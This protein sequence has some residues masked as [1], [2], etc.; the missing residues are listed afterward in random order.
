MRGD[1]LATFEAHQ[2][3][4]GG[5][6]VAIPKAPVYIVGDAGG[7]GDPIMGEGIY[8]ALESGRI[9]GETIADCVAG[10][11]SHA[12]YYERLKP[13]VLMDTFVTY[14]VSREFYRNVDKALTIL[15]NPFIWRPFVEGY[16]A[17]ATFSRSIAKAWWL[18]PKAV[19]L[20]DLRY[21]RAGVS[22]PMALGGP[23]RG[24]PYLCEPLLRRAQRRLGLRP[25]PPTREGSV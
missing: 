2:F 9:A 24:L 19:V 10:T 15:E 5:Y 25:S 13:S 12:T 17:G 23:F 11:A 16:A 18:L 8:H 3:P 14:Q 1:P 20:N 22:Q 21:E 6:R 4:Y 7:F